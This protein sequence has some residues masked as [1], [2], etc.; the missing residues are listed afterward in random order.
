MDSF[1]N[2]KDFELLVQDRYTFAV[3]DRILKEDCD[4]IRADHESLI[5]CHS[6]SRF[7][8]WIWTPD[9]CADS[10]KEKTWNLAAECRPPADGY[11]FNMKYEL[12]DY[13]MKK[14]EQAGLKIGI[15]MQLF[16]YDCP[17]P[18]VPDH[19]TDGCLYR[20]MPEDTEEAADL[21]ALFYHEIG[22][23][24]PTREYCMEKAQEHIDK[25]AFFFWKNANGKAV[26]C[27]SYRVNQ[28]LASLASVFTLPEYRRKYYAQHLVYEVTK[29]VSDLGYTPMLYTDANYLASNACYEKIGY[30]LRGKLCTI[31]K[32]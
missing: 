23:K 32:N 28:E 31:A 2:K 21:I 18:A 26:A 5:L 12:A 16:A 22:E 19:L 6:A 7:P 25:N 1:V 13:F 8:V 30:V 15:H 20:C 9:G 27:C 3:L 24:P 10:V 17:T 11:R 29:L 14:A 4:L